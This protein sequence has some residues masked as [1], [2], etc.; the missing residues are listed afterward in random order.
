MSKK[1][2]L[3][4]KEYWEKREA[5]KLK[6]GLKD[7]L[8]RTDL[9]EEEIGY[10]NELISE[11]YEGGCYQF[12]ASNELIEDKYIKYNDDIIGLETDVSVLTKKFIESNAS[13]F[14]NP[15]LSFETMAKTTDVGYYYIDNYGN[16]QF[17][18]NMKEIPPSAK[19]GSV[20]A[21]TYYDICY[22]TDSYKVLEKVDTDSNI[23]NKSSNYNDLYNSLV[24]DVQSVG[25]RR[26]ELDNDNKDITAAYHMMLNNKT[27]LNTYLDVYSKNSSI[28]NSVDFSSNN[29]LSNES[30]IN[31]SNK[32]SDILDNKNIIIGD[33]GIS[34]IN[35]DND[36]MMHLYMS[37]ANGLDNFTISGN[38]LVKPDGTKVKIVSKGNDLITWNLL[39]DVL[40]SSDGI[41]SLN[42]YMDI[43]ETVVSSEIERFKNDSLV[44]EKDIPD[45]NGKYFVYADEEQSK[46]I[47]NS[48][49][50][51]GNE[52]IVDGNS[53]S[54]ISSSGDRVYVKTENNS[55]EFTL[56]KSNTVI[57]NDSTL[58]VDSNLWKSRVTD[59]N[60]LNAL[61]YVYNTGS[62]EN[63]KEYVD[64]IFPTI[65]NRWVDIETEKD[66]FKA[67]IAP[68]LSSVQSVIFGIPE[69][70]STFT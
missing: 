3:S 25:T 5:Y 40:E 43:D 47:L 27:M 48:I 21:V 7:L 55:L 19:D 56:M 31:L 14:S 39:K 50:N 1:N 18:Y 29:V 41:K 38:F 51:G 28:L 60:Y 30:I 22:G 23:F 68:T 49:K 53:I 70:F 15:F 35:V 69:G 62:I 44:F 20:E 59:F 65:D 37:S 54:Y 17:V 42:G 36:D 9:S 16:K 8:N 4:S 33:D 58:L 32:V 2:N 6:K 26:K 66:N 64:L 12:L 11:K 52:F 57:N 45:Y 10:L 61:N 13:N 67:D 46:Y 34:V 24:T 63:V